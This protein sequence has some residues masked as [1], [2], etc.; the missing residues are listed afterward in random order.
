MIK[1][2]FQLIFLALFLAIPVVSLAETVVRTGES[3]SI[4]SDQVV[5]SDFYAA[6]KSVM[7]SGEVVGDMYAVGA[8]VTINGPIGGDLTVLGGA[9]NIN[10]DVADDVRLISGEAIISGKVTG[11]VFVMGGVLKVLSSA[12]VD[13]NVYFYGGE[14]EISGPVKG[15]VMGTAESFRIDSR[16]EG[17]VDVVASRSLVLGDRASVDGDISYQSIA[18]ITRAQQ[19]VVG[20]EVIRNTAPSVAEKSSNFNI[21]PA[22][23]LIFATLCL[24]LFFKESLGKL[25][26]DILTQPARATL[27]GLATF[28][29]GPPAAVLMILTVLGSLVGLVT[30]F[31]LFVLYLIAFPVMIMVLG[32]LTMRL[33]M[34]DN[35]LTL[36]T[37]AVGL[38]AFVLLTMIPV[39]GPIILL[40]A[41]IL[42]LGGLA[43]QGYKILF[44]K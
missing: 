1:N 42:T 43:Y 22:F 19:A 17:G 28:F 36:V 6:G 5:E 3:V 21:L 29:A 26:D 2:S 33:T 40:G 32:G 39:A 16:I 4:E 31:G 34:K 13:G 35:D 14:A 41:F 20:G 23:V 44:I 18:E 30:L 25:V 10:S 9:I 24:F 27:I 11:D 15:S 38:V 12:S 37:V 7:H 8:S